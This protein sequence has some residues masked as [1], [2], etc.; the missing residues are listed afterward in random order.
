M[1]AESVLARMGHTQL[2]KMSERQLRATLAA[3]VNA[4]QNLATKMDTLATKLNNDAGVTD[5]N[6]ATDF[7][8]TTAA[9]ITD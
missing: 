9:I 1:S 6:Y 4:V 5:V 2:D 8:T 7:A 3:L